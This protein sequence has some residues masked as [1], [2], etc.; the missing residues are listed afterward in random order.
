MNK[1]IID[2]ILSRYGLKLNEEFLLKIDSS[3][4]K[5]HFE[6]SGLYSDIGLGC[7]NF[8]K[9]IFL[10]KC[11]IEKCILI[12]EETEYLRNVIGERMKEVKYISK[13]R[14]IKIIT[15]N[16]IACLFNIKETD[17]LQFKGMEHSKYYT[18]EELILR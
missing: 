12:E 4:I 15:E 11:E 16:D 6:E 5:L 17:K 7:N 10:G 3:K 1:A 9:G 18:P 14:C 2:T 8:L 13:D